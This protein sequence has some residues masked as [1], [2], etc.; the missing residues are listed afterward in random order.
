MKMGYVKA[1]RLKTSCLKTSC[2]KTSCL[3]TCRM[4]LLHHFALVPDDRATM[5]RLPPQNP[6]AVDGAR[7]ER[8]GVTR[9]AVAVARAAVARRAIARAAGE[10]RLVEGVVAR[11]GSGLAGRSCGY[12]RL[13]L[14]LGC[15]LDDGALAPDRR[16]RA[17]V[18]V[19]DVRA[20][21][22]PAGVID[23]GGL[24]GE[25]D[26]DLRLRKRNVLLGGPEHA[27]DLLRR[28]VLVRPRDVEENLGVFGR[29]LHTHAAVALGAHV[30]REHVLVRRV[31]LI[32]QEP[33][34]K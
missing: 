24:I 31:V 2:L 5:L 22:Q 29:V 6:S 12:L 15:R 1:S 10:H 11:D 25:V 26:P 33:V 21:L 4:S 13:A 30:V 14:A 32:D 9:A 27:P 18:E 3:K 7:R 16:K 20:D 23:K 8:S 34:G 19:V 17:A 28:P